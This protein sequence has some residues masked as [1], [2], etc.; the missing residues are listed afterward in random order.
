MATSVLPRERA[1]A[2]ERGYRR[3]LVPLVGND[4]SSRAMEVACQLAAEQGASITALTVIEVPPLLPLDA[5]MDDEE[6]A[7]RRLLDRAQATADAYGVSVKLAR[8]RTRDAA[9]TILEAVE[10]R[11]V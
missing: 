5:Y 9:A 6:Q 3:L 7:A 4:E 1:A 10:T 8:V 11:G 2:L